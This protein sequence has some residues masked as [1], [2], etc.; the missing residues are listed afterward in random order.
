M[1]PNL[2][3]KKGLFSNL[4][5]N[6]TKIL[7][8][9]QCK[10]I[11]HLTIDITARPIDLI[12][13]FIKKFYIKAKDI[14]YQDL[15]FDEIELEANEVKIIFKLTNKELSFKNNLIVQFKISISENSLKKIL[16]S[17]HWSWIEEIISKKLLTHSKLEDLKIRND[18]ITIITNHPNEE[19]RINIKVIKNKIYLESKKNNKSF[20][21]PLED[22]VKVENVNIKNNVIIISANSL[23]S[24]N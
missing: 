13:G 6:G 20:K 22:K 21:I 24:F 9:K 12:K 1:P 5:E 17:D 15:L 14:N 3:K 7:L 8:K 11:G 16:L 19:V 4:L 10:K 18:N 23:V 2:N